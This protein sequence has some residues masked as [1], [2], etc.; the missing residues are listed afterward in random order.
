MSYALNRLPLS[1]GAIVAGLL[2]MLVLVTISS[3]SAHA[4]AECAR[5]TRVAGQTMLTNTCGQCR[6]IQ[7]IKDRSGNA[8]PSLRTFVL[9][10]GEQYALPFKGPGATR[11]T[12]DA[13]CQ[14]LS[15][16]EKKEQDRIAESLQHCVIP[17]MT[18]RGMVLANG[19][20]ACR[21]IIIE[22]RYIDGREIHKSYALES[23]DVLALADEG[24]VAAEIVHDT[25]CRLQ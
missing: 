18:S 15:L 3:P 7:V 1:V 9:N 17:V 8:L 2:V 13:N 11:V 4:A 14:D 21:T 19:C 12:S 25:A 22:R 20:D 10:G 23:K 24:A 16:A 5:V 6:S